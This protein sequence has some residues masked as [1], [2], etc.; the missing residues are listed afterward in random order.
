MFELLKSDRIH[1]CLHSTPSPATTTSHI[2][3]AIIAVTISTITLATTSNPFLINV[4]AYL[5]YIQKDVCIV[6]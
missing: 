5:L 6:A 1:A 3:A 4:I 2:V